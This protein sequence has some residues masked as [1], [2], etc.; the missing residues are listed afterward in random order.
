VDEAKEIPT[1][2]VLDLPTIPKEKSFPPRL[3][4]MALGTMLAAFGGIS[5]CLAG[6]YGRERTRLILGKS[7]RKRS[8]I[9]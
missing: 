6:R 7:S 4:I 8:S 1:V 5:G 9:P 2:Q 3:L